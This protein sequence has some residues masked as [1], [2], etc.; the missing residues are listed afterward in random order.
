MSSP[1]RSP[2][3]TSE[4]GLEQLGLALAADARLQALFDKHGV[5]LHYVYDYGH[6]AVRIGKVEASGTVTL[7]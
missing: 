6:G 3:E 4:H 7:I 1:G 5:S 2:R